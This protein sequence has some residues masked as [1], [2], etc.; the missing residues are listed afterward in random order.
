VENGGSTKEILRMLVT[1]HTYRLS[2][3]RNASNARIDAENQLRWR[4]PRRRLEAEALRDTILLVSGELKLAQPDCLLPESAQSETALNRANLD[5][6]TIVNPPY[7]SVYVPVFREEGLNG[8]MEVFDFA[9]PS[10]TAG[11]RNTSTLPTQALYLMNSPFIMAQSKTAAQS[12]IESGPADLDQ[13]ITIAFESA[14]GRP[15]SRD[16]RQLMNEILAGEPDNPD[17]WATLYHTLFASVDFR[18][19]R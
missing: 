5:V 2:S 10:F 9:N 15:P 3:E 8:L 13:R 17:R 4:M 7:R 16:E 6:A 1:S 19:L 12:L 18:Y 11:E 14:I